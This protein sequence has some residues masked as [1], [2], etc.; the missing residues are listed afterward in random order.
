MTATALDDDNDANWLPHS[1]HT[2]LTT[3]T[4]P[5]CTPAKWD[6]SYHKHY[7]I[8]IWTF[9]K[10]PYLCPTMT[11]SMTAMNDPGALTNHLQ[12][13]YLTIKSGTLIK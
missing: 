10:W 9:S 2:L 3:V 13:S 12:I 5:L 8:C 4:P 11:T 6:A 1:Q 7:R